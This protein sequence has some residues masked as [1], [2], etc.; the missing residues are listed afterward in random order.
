MQACIDETSATAARQKRLEIHT[1]LL[2]MV[3]PFCENS[4]LF[5]V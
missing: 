2:H 5:S 4:I 1:V 3:G